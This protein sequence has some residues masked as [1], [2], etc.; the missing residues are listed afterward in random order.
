MEKGGVALSWKVYV[1]EI[2]KRAKGDSSEIVA[3]NENESN[4]RE[5]AL[6]RNAKAGYCTRNG[7]P[8]NATKIMTTIPCGKT[9]LNIWPRDENGQLIGD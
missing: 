7:E 4:V 6:R 3:W 9:K 2:L 1:L 5:E 8:R